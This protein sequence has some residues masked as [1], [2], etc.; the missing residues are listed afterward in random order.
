MPIINLQP[1]EQAQIVY[2][3][4]TAISIDLLA[5]G[6]VWRTE[7]IVMQN[8]AGGEWIVGENFE[9]TLIGM[10]ANVLSMR[11]TAKQKRNLL[12]EIRLTLGSSELIFQNATIRLAVEQAQ[13]YF[14]QVIF[15]CKG[16]R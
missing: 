12:A 14:Q 1:I 16:T 4:G 5:D 7:E 11:D 9:I 8:D 3:D 13:V 2:S 6:S 10:G 15:I